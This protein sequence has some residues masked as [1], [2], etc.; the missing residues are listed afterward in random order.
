MDIFELIYTL[1]KIG[2]LTP[3]A[4][5]SLTES[6]FKYGINIMTLLY[7]AGME[8]ED[9]TALVD[10]HESLSFK[11]L[12]AESEVLSVILRK[13]YGLKS[14]RKA[15]FLC[16]N[17]CSL[18]KSIFAVSATGADI[19]LLNAEMSLNQFNRILENNGFNLLIYDFELSPLVEQSNY[20]KDKIISYHD[21]LPAI[22][23]LSD[24]KIDE[25]V[26]QPRTS[27]SKI[28]LLSGGTTGNFKEAM[29]KPSLFNYL[30]PFLAVI[31]R[32][33]LLDHNTTYIATPIYH[34]YG[35]S[36]LFLFIA[37][38]KKVVINSGFDAKEACSIIR[39]HGVEVVSAVPLMI[40]KMLD[41]N[42]ED[43]KSIA[44]IAS[45][46][47]ELNPKL[48][49]EVFNKLGDVLYNLYGTSETGLNMI[50]TPQDLKYSATTIGRKI[51]GM[52]LKILDSKNKEVETGTVGRFC[53]KNRWSMISSSESWI[54]TGDLG[55]RDSK[56]Y[57]YLCGRVDDMIV[58]AGENVYPFEV[59]QVLINHP[60][61]KEAA[62]IGISDEKFGHR[63]KAFVHTVNN[64]SITKEELFEWLRHRVARFQ[65]PK[66]I[67]FVDNIPYT[68]LGKPD[69][70]QLNEKM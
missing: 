13:K 70:K 3:S 22:N 53:V 11:Q 28:V 43:L 24:E 14:G 47:A 33:K 67:I 48:V 50:A 60:E 68:P 18:V 4:L 5:F 69:R 49:Y 20:D 35:I 64:S 59:E 8:Y 44:C 7:F 36:L 2:L 31:T 58:S 46:G 39:E 10:K 40:Y 26:K 23:N 19:Y 1:Y 9:K 63:L 27:K 17:H 52:Q 45:G 57:Y 61:V 32:L 62:V 37:L 21:S 15:G 34:G 38:G 29:H 51:N 6:V 54:E 65:M 56:G 30:K 42:A 16:K 41:N 25:R 12:L 66:D 55:C